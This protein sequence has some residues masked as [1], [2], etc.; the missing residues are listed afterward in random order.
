M[1]SKKQERINLS[2][3]KVPTVC[4]DCANVIHPGGAVVLGESGRIICRKCLDLVLNGATAKPA[5]KEA[6]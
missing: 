1:D 4:F 2:V 5:D 3:K 6:E